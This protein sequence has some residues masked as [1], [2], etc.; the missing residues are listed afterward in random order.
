MG[1]LIDGVGGGGFRATGRD[2]V[3]GNL[4]TDRGRGRA[5]MVLSGAERV[6]RDTD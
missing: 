6:E 4:T 1:T 3:G 5:E 2:G